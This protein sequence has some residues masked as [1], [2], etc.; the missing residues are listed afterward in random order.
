MAAGK[1]ERTGSFSDVCENASAGLFTALKNK[2]PFF[3]K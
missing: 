3:S 1:Y 2:K